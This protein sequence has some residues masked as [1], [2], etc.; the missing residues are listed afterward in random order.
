MFSLDW[1]DMVGRAN[2]SLSVAAQYEMSKR[3][4]RQDPDVAGLNWQAERV[5]I[6][7]GQF[8]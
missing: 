4:C 5:A 3:N 2:A 1:C 6:F 8:S 7:V